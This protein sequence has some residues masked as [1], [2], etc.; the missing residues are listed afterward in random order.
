MTE[1]RVERDALGE[2]QVPA[3]AL[4]G[5]QTQR[6]I[7]NF[8]ISGIRFPRVFIKAIGLVKMCAAKVNK[9]LGL[10][11][12]QKANAIM[13][14]AKEVVDGKLDEHFPLDIFQTGSG[15]ST[16]MNANEVIANRACEILGGKRGDKLLVHPNDHVNLG[17]S[18]NDVIPACI[19]ISAAIAINEQLL[20]A[21][22]RLHVVLSE[23]AKEFDDIVKTGRTHLMDAMPVRL[24]QEFSGYAN[25]IAWC[26][27]RIEATL[28]RLYELALGGT[29]VGTS[30]NTHPE[31]GKR[32]AEALAQETG[33]PFKETRNH[34]ASQ[35]AMETAV[36]VSGALKT[37]AVALYKIANDLR[38]MNSGPQ[39]GLAE[40]RLPA[41]QPGSSI[42]PGKINPVIPEAVM[43]V[44]MQVFGNDV[45][46]TA[47]AA[48]GNFELNVALPVIAHN[49]LQSIT[50]LANA[51]DVFVSKCVAG[52]VANRE[53][54]QRLAAQNAILATALTPH[55]GYD[56]AAEVVKKAMAENKTIREV[57]LDMGLMSEEELDKVLDIR[58]MT[59]GGFVAGVSAGG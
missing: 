2:V 9:E 39:A 55:I 31:F 1:M 16:N 36:E 11:D 41:L 33:I 23:K 49:L 4:W 3:W 35:A 38:W 34:F 5:A 26:K 22:D 42:M 47:A 29:A 37:L 17:Q 59:E 20:P 19:H 7:E 53:H 44:S 21:L 10:L 25:Q 58:K 54:M 32:I 50:I 57:V 40:I 28:P 24:G 52:I 45:A 43:M 46:I 8:P 12:E 51:C 27:E 56:K 13:E 14:A 18:S 6:A 30:I 48:S 15:T